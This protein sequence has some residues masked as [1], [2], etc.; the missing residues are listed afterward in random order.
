MDETPENIEYF[1][2]TYSAI[3][4]L[5]GAGVIKQRKAPGFDIN[6]DGFNIA[7]ASQYLFK[8]LEMPCIVQTW[9]QITKK[10]VDE[11]NRFSEIMMTQFKGVGVTTKDNLSHLRLVPKETVQPEPPN[12]GA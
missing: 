8:L 6:P 11:L 1:Y 7:A 5:N 10:R 9:T 4:I 2:V 3:G 12:K